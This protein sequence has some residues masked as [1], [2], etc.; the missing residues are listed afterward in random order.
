MDEQM[1]MLDQALADHCHLVTRP[2]AVKLAQDHEPPP[3]KIK[4]PTEH[5][6]HRL[7]V[8]QGMTIA[9]TLGW[10]MAFR[11]KDHACPL[12]KIFM[13]H[14]A[15]DRFLEGAQGEFYQD[16]PDCMRKMEASYPRWPPGHFQEIWLSPLDKCEF[17]PDLIVAYGNPAQILALIQA[18]NFRSGPGLT[19]TSSGRYGC[20]AWIAGAVQA[21][22]CTYMVPGPGERIFAATQD[23]EMS[24]ALPYPKIDQVIEGLEYVRSR[25]AYRYPVPNMGI[26]AEP[27]IPA[28]YHDI[29]PESQTDS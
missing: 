15:P 26:L 18:A 12:P 23:H 7:A 24:F 13:G 2:V 29:D 19:S 21:G 28:A 8:C 9:R 25:G 6:G 17:V 11:K 4:Y 14:I 5:V 16:Q 20:S 3:Q 10:S 27:R 1:K 22:E